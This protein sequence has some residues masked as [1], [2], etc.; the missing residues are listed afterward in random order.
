MRGVTSRARVS[1]LT[2]E[3]PIVDRA[4]SALKTTAA[5]FGAISSV[6]RTSVTVQGPEGYLLEMSYDLGNFL[7][8]RVYNL[9][10]T[11]VLP[12]DSRVPD[13]LQLNFKDRAGPRYVHR[14][15]RVA[16][17]AIDELNASLGSLLQE[18]DLAGS[19]V[20]SDNGTKRLT[21]SPL[22]GSFVWVLI[23]PVFTPTAFPAG[24]PERILELITTMRS[25]IS[26][27]GTA[28]RKGPLT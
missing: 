19:A 20:E 22:G 27:D 17:P 10:I 12:V 11:S 26:T 6:T 8:S 7:F 25:F 14:N 28:P 9:T 15:D 16:D 1:P 5:K 2:K 21:L 13:G 18:I 23:P 3:G 24:E 4:R